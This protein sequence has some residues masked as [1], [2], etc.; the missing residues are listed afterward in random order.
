LSQ[1][2]PGPGEDLA[3]GDEHLSVKVFL[4]IELVGLR[5]TTPSVQTKG[6]K[7]TYLPRQLSLRL[8]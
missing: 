1:V 4:V 7:E 8:L 3:P 6:E 5:G 2:L